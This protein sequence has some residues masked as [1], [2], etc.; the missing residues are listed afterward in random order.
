[1]ILY[2]ERRPLAGVPN[3]G[4]AFMAYDLARDRAWS[5]SDRSAGAPMRGAWSPDGT[6]IAFIAAGASGPDL[7]VADA[8]GANSINLTNDAA[9]D[10]DPAWSPDG[11]LLAFA[12]ERYPGVRL[13]T[14]SPGGSAPRQ[15]TTGFARDA[16]PLWVSTSALVFVREEPGGRRDLWALSLAS[17]APYRLSE[18]GDVLSIVAPADGS[19]RWIERLTITPIGIFDAGVSPG[20][21]VRLSAALHDVSG[22]T[23]Q[24]EAARLRWRVSDTLVAAMAPDG[25]LT[26]RAPG[27]AWA[28]ANFGGWVADSIELVARE[29]VEAPVTL[30][31]YED[32]SRGLTS[33]RW[34]RF[35]TPLPA[36][37]PTG[38]PEGAGV[39]INRGDATYPT[40]VV[41][42]QAFATRNGLTVEVWARM[43]FSGGSDQHF[44]LGLLTEGVP[45]DRAEWTEAPLIVEFSVRGAGTQGRVQALVRLGRTEHPIPVPEALDEWRRYELQLDADGRVSLVID[46]RLYWRSLD[47]LQPE[48]LQPAHVVLGWRSVGTEVA[49]GLL[50]AYY[51][52][53]YRLAAPDSLAA[54]EALP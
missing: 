29:L 11:R 48:A 17:G 13:F 49:H 9:I 7:F 44:G 26:V 15:V 20:Q 47:G 45:G 38:G 19:G 16:L 54:R 1:V 2:S 33:G 42:R 24:G 41:S 46:G 18:R 4:Y 8:D 40:G 5:I 50:R 25:W 31:L 3:H 52:S 28:V 10:L 6:R 36:T 51:G 34:I 12:S 14:V 39:F 21:R 27:R 23:V 32:W 22:A 35:G 37:R 43:P 53:R 30:L